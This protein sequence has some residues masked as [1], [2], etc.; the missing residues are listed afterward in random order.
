MI[1]APTTTTDRFSPARISKRI[2][3]LGLFGLVSAGCFS[4]RRRT[5]RPQLTARRSTIFSR[6]SPSWKRVKK[7]CGKV[8]APFNF[9]RR[10]PR[11]RSSSKARKH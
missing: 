3:R 11:R 7:S 2:I 6:E 9:E 4:R 5:R 8:V 10:R 1:L